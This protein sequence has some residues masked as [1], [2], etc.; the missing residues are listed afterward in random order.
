M[1]PRSLYAVVDDH[2]G[3]RFEQARPRAERCLL[4][5]NCCHAPTNASSAKSHGSHT[6]WITLCGSR[7][8]DVKHRVSEECDFHVPALCAAQ[9]N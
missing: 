9:L 6:T 8:M 2:E 3:R 5:E 4:L 7:Y 1:G